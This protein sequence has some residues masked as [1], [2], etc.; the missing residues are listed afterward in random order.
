MLLKNKAACFPAALFS[1]IE[2]LIGRRFFI[3]IVFLFYGR[4][5]VNDTPAFWRCWRRAGERHP[6]N[7]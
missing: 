2:S 7:R 5:G 3:L 4:F 6:T 1:G